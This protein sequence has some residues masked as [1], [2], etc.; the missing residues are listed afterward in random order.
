MDACSL[1]I[2]AVDPPKVSYRYV[3]F[4]RY[5]CTCT[6]ICTMYMHVYVSDVLRCAEMATYMYMYMYVKITN[7]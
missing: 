1:V 7:V 4:I 5:N 2:S 3:G 6:C